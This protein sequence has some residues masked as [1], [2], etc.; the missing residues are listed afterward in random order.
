MGAILLFTRLTFPL[1]E[2]DE[3]RYA[4]I[5]AGMLD[6]GDWLVPAREGSVYL[7]KPPLLYW[8]TLASYHVLGVHDYAARMVTALA[9]MGTLLAT[10]FVGRRLVG[11]RA[12]LV[13]GALLLMSLGFLLASRF[14]IMD[15][16]LTCFTTLTLLSMYAATQDSRLRIG[17][18]LAASIACGLGVMTKG[19]IALV[20][21]IPPLFAV[22]WLRSDGAKIRLRDWLLFGVGV[23]AIALPWFIAVA[24]REPSFLRYFFWEHHVM[25]Y[26][27]NMVHVE[28]WWFYGVALVVGM[29]PA[30][31]LLPILPIYLF[32]RDRSLA[33]C[34]TRSQGFLLLTG[35]WTV[36][37]FSLATGKLA[38]YILPA[39]PPLCLL[40][41]AMLDAAVLNEISDAFMTRMRRWIPYHGTRCALIAAV[42]LGV[43]DYIVDQGEPDQWAESIL[44]IAGAVVLYWYVSRRVFAERTARWYAAAAIPL[45][46]MGVGL[47]DIYPTIA[48]KRSLAM[49]VATLRHAQPGQT[50]GL[51][52]YGRYEDSLV[53]YNRDTSI[54]LFNIE[55]INEINSYFQTHSRVLIL[56]QED[57]IPKLR[58]QLPANVT[59]TEQPMSRGK[60]FMAETTTTTAAGTN[61]AGAAAKTAR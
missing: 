15:G 58:E 46:L 9:G 49:Q 30:S 4:L 7:D 5:A 3:S 52:C 48:T 32:R 26:T 33:A 18:W 35:V 53:F 14:L 36:G 29:A 40:L 56:S 59:I 24:I 60:L 2:P 16:L 34:R 51:V 12:A 57:Y 6:S 27:T 10:Y 19:P 47:I 13:G 43:A 44:L 25:R 42:V 11:A 45:V 37:F 17:W 55:Q 8:L 31:F 1:I 39:L 20:L 50:P 21:T 38:P 54:P 23:T 22:N 41:G 61:A 28:P